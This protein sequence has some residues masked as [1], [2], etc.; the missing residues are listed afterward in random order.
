MLI[1]AD[2]RE[3]FLFFDAFGRGVFLLERRFRCGRQG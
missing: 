3:A 1:D 2:W